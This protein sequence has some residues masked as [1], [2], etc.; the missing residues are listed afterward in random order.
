MKKIR[1]LIL[2]LGFIWPFLLLAADCY[3]STTVKVG[4]TTNPGFI[5]PKMD[6][7]YDGY[8]VVYLQEIA[9]YTN[10]KY[11][12]VNGSMPEL[13]TA[14][15]K[16]QIDLICNLTYTPERGE[17]FDYS[18]YPIGSEASLLYMS[19]GLKKD[20]QAVLDINGLT[21][22]VT[23]GT[24]QQRSLAEYFQK[25]GFSYHEVAFKTN[26][27]LFRALNEGRLDAVASTSMYHTDAYKMASLFAVNPIF[28]V[29]SKHRQDD[30]MAQV[31]SALSQIFY[32]NP[33]FTSKLRQKYYSRNAATFQPLFTKDELAFIKNCQELKVGHFSKRFPFSF[34]NQA[35][36]KISGITVD[37]LRLISIKSGLNFKEEGIEVGKQ[38]LE[39]LYNGDYD[40][41]T[42]IVYNSDRL[43]NPK[44]FITTPYYQGRMVIVGHK[45]DYLHPDKSYTIALPADAK[46]IRYY[47]TDNFENYTIL[48]Y[49]DSQECMEAV[50]RGEADI[51]MQNLHIV[52]ALLQQPRFEN[53][54]IWPTNFYM[55]EDF[56]I[57][58]KSTA[59]PLLIS[60]LNKTI[61]SLDPNEVHNIILKYTVNRP[62]ELT[63]SDFLYKYKSGISLIIVFGVFVIM[64]AVYVM[65]QKRKNIALLTQKNI[66]LSQAISQAQVANSA[67][68]QFL[69][70]MSHEIR[71]P[72][73]AVTGLT[74]LA[75]KNMDKKERVEDYLHK[76]TLSSS[77][78]LNIVNDIL[79][80]SA[81]ENDKLK[82]VN[83][84][85]NLRELLSSISS[86]YYTQCKNKKLTFEVHLENV[87]EERLIG[88]NVRLNQILLNLLSNAVKFTPEGGTV[89]LT[90][91]RLRQDE[92]KVFLRFRVSDTGI[93]MSEEFQQRIFK[94]FEQGT[95]TTFQKYGGSGLGLSITKNLTELMN[96]KIEVQSSLGEGTTFT[97]DMPLGLVKQVDILGKELQKTRVFNVLIVDS[98]AKAQASASLVLERLGLKHTLAVSREEAVRLSEAALKAGKPYDMVFLDW[99]LLEKDELKLGHYFRQ[100]Y[101]DKLLIIVMAYDHDEVLEKSGGLKIDG[102]ID[103]P[104]FQSS[105][106]NLLM[107]FSKQIY[108]PQIEAPKEMFLQGRRLLLV[109]DHPIN[110]EIAT[111]LLKM[112]GAKV[113]CA[114]NGQ[115][116]VDKFRASLP[117][118]YDLIL[119]D[120]QMPILN[121]YEAAKAIRL[122]KHP[123][124]ATIPIVAMTAD[125]FT[126]DVSR[127]L[128]AGMNE[129]IAKPI[130]VK[131]M[132]KVL[133]RFL[134]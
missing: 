45:N 84:P 27:E 124:A 91:G 8:G 90:V 15:Q 54:E 130:D 92:A 17:Q 132:L 63:V 24:F 95:L 117:G 128:A 12:Y 71:T 76:I 58:S 103:K 57:V 61:D 31:N 44:I 39:Q 75:L 9:K 38:P 1:K 41:I 11:R 98:D 133:A 131:V 101:Q 65:N 6:G 16:G 111:E 129:H 30:L 102:F 66:Q 18:A 120:I 40:L 64:I 34:I 36:Q 83:Q 121:G 13:L 118:Y 107:Q 125:A 20:G 114:V 73:N 88:D 46:G 96:G 32:K 33:E 119:M 59:N 123:S 25:Q 126:E 80:M 53:L 109:E 56:S 28:M 127:A 60:I 37:I 82:I 97:V 67:K 93:G 50:N 52:N 19:P 4:Y 78:L 2:L 115:D 100:T 42:G 79:D 110:R 72:L 94:P 49:Q 22:G 5:E 108:Q 3:A 87:V 29:A 69:S 104:L 86:L 68:S 14:L 122:S 113:E 7:T 70:R 10:W 21:I 26:E 134:K 51:M 74:A 62:Y 116:G 55:D 81:I 47:I 106:F 43:S 105:V 35:S 99:N 112:A 77:M 23:E 48:D 89:N 85:F